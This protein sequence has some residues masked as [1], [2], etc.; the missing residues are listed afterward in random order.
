MLILKLIQSEVYVL[1]SIYKQ[2]LP[3]STEG[4]NVHVHCNI[5]PYIYMYI[6]I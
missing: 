3:I 4:I 5:I 6:I 2:E 1:E